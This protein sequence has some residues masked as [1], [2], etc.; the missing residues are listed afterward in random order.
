MAGMVPFQSGVTRVM[1]FCRQTW[2]HYFFLVGVQQECDRLRKSLAK[3]EM[4]RNR[5]FESEQAL[6]RLQE[7]LE[8]NAQA[9][10][11]MLPAQVTGVDPSGWFKTVIINKGQSHGVLKEMAVLSTKGLV[12]HVIKAFDQS[13]MVLLIIDPASAVDALIQRSRFRGI[14]EGET[15]VSCRL[16]YVVRKADV[17]IGDLV[18]SSGLDGIFP[19]GLRIGTISQV[20]NPGTGLFQNAKVKPLVDFSRLEEVLVIVE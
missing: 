11:R 14:V 10:Y 13:A 17:K 19:K 4:E 6:Q 8:T 20:L 9:P 18:L 2:H 12:G 16:K 3:V 15:A 1:H 7:L 5:R